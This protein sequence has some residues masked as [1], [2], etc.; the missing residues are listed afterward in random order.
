MAKSVDERVVQMEFDN[1]QFESGIKTSLNSLDKLKKGLNFDAATKSLA[2][3][4]K[5]TK[6]FSVAGIEKGIDTISSKFTTLGI[7]GVTALQRI[8]NA[9]I[10]AGTNLVKS[11]TIDPVLTG[12]NEYE[13][14]MN[15]ITTILTNTASKG[16]TLD[17]V[18]NA[19]NELNTYA[20][21]TIYNFAEMTRN[22][23][24]FTAAGVD[25]ETATKA[26]QGIANLAAGSGSSSAQAS[27]AMYQL[28]QAIAAGRVSLQDWN[29]V[30]NAGMGGELF[31]NALK[32]TAK[33]MGIVVDESVSF[34]ES[35]SAAGGQESWLTSDVLVKTLEKFAD[36]ETLLKAAT[37][38][39]TFT[40]LIDTM[41]ESVQSG[42]AQSWEYIIGDR[43][44]AAEL[45]TSISDG[46]NSIIQPSTDARNAALQFWNANGGRAAVIEGITNVLKTLGNILK[47]IGDAF[48]DAFPAITGERLVDISEKFRDLTENFKIGEGTAK[49]IKNTFSGLFSVVQ[50]FGKAIGA[51]IKP[52]F[53]FTDTLGTLASGLLSVTGGIGDFVTKLNQSDSIEQSL[54]TISDG[55]GKAVDAI[56]DFISSI[57]KNTGNIDGVLGD[58]I[59]GAVTIIE[60]GAGAL[61]DAIKWIGEHV[62]LGDVFAGLAGGGIFVAAKKLSGLFDTIKDALENL[63]GGGED[64]KKFKENFSDILSSVHDSIASFSTGIKVSSLLTISVAVGILSASLNSLSKLKVTDIAKSVTAVGILMT[65]LNLSFRS[66]TKSLSKFDS[67]GIL[68][69]GLST[70]AIAGAI[71]IL[72]SAMTDLAK[73]DLGGIGKGL[74]GIGGMLTEL[75]LFFKATD[76]KSISLKGSVGLIAIAGAI[77]IMADAIGE[78]ASLSWSEVARGL[79][80]MGIGLAELVAGIKILNG[81]KVSIST[82]IAIIALAEACVILSDAVKSFSSMSWE[83]IGR[84][85][86]SMGIALAELVAAVSILGK[87]GGF[88]SLLGGTSIL[89]I[90]QALHDIYESLSDFGSMSWGEIGKGLTAMGAA[91]T[92]LGVV[93]GVL[94]KIAGFSGILGSTTIVIAVQALEPIANTLQKIG[95]LSWEE[96]AKGLVGMGLAL[97][98][99]ALIVGTLGSFAGI[100]SLLAGGAILIA[101]QSLEPISNALQSIST[102]SWEEIAK[103]LVGMG[104][105]LGEVALIVG[106]LGMV[107][108]LGGILAGGA[109]LIAIQGLGD[110]ASALQQ[111][112]S[113]TWEEI[114]K[115]LVGMGAALGEL[116]I[117]TGLLG[118]L[119]PLGGIIGSG[120]ILI[121]VQ[122][123]GDLADALAKFGS[124]SWDEIGKGLA[125]MGAALGEVALGGLLNTLSGFGA[126]AIAEV[127]PALGTLADSLS[128]WKNVSVPEGLGEQ[129]GTLASGVMKFTFG[130]FGAGALST[131]AA[132]LGDMA[133]AVKKWQGV[134]I[135]EG[136]KE[137]LTNIADGVK[138]FTWAFMGGFSIGEI[139]E[140]LKNLA[141]AVRRW[142]GIEIPTN[143]KEGLSG[144][145]DGV[146]SF[147][148]AFIGGWS[149]GEIAEPLKNL[150]TA[151]RRWNG[152]EIPEGIGDS[153]SRLAK[154]VKSF[155]G[156]NYNTE[157]LSSVSSGLRSLGV[158]AMALSGINFALIGT[159]LS[160]FATAIKNIPS[161]ISGVS[162]SIQ[163]SVSQ[164]AVAISSQAGNVSA[165]F[166]TLVMSGLSSLSSM[167]PL[168]A[169]SGRSLGMSLVTALASSL[170]NGS[171]L[172]VSSGRTLGLSLVAALSVSLITGVPSVVASANVLFQ[173]VLTEIQRAIQNSRS[174][175]QNEGKLLGDALLKGLTSQKAQIASSL[176]TTIS[177]V[178]SRLNQYQ[179]S[180]RAAGSGM[181]AGLANGI[182]AG[183]SNVINAAIKVASDALAAAKRELDS[184]S[185]SKKFEKLGRDSDQGLING[186]LAMASRVG[187]AGK[188]VGKSALSSVG[189][190]MQQIPSLLS[191]DM[192][193]TPTITPVLDLDSIKTG[194]NT[195]DRMMNRGILLRP[196]GRI[197]NLTVAGDGV[198]GNT[199]NT[200][201]SY[202]QNNYSPKALS[203][204]EIYRQTRNQFST[205]K[206][207]V[208]G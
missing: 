171:S 63:F 191:D 21:K 143:L 116:A 22:I 148:W 72:T 170:I 204:K 136:I 24:T 96:I 137:G 197:S 166:S 146:K 11:L 14:K 109:I 151:V 95:A 113:M 62:S 163:S 180:F 167:G 68:R 85:L 45:F 126:G 18:N 112:G 53:G 35:I 184:H 19:L 4:E 120:S 104:L 193:I 33:Q 57:F 8:T 91:L 178:V 39:K 133:T 150:A 92:E 54:N 38:V 169:S 124:M 81:S 64:V 119:A 51:V 198:P 44:Q 156:E 121:A 134:E 172:C 82:S 47:P 9:A 128:K 200:T 194:M 79:T 94:G 131:A 108:P 106:A 25:L 90:T 154:G 175:I 160:N 161:E 65:E 165:A 176:D 13:T 3:I 89:I 74:L 42:W 29:S 130:G 107:A 71:A 93:S 145:A 117:I 155:G 69:A 10:T 127:A 158:S 99:V 5:A 142:S 102:L 183:R 16:T 205:I 6:N 78:L 186:L 70:I 77:S 15:A 34:R 49:N 75:S 177:S 138:A 189:I 110:L 115:G 55:L 31:Q 135:P 159:N 139:V 111:F 201:F 114:A 60:K 162:T 132:S 152:I 188:A 76:L 27:T 66:L 149:I 56:N 7:I 141:T 84:G 208:E 12:F 195:M 17:D 174:K 206:K 168:Y 199:G 129:L 164:I 123:L 122:G 80:A 202:V 87:F 48:K 83:E 140:P 179:G 196:N 207:R 185:P 125:A 37:Q 61:A 97:G 32:E 67:K 73:L 28:S 26:I 46:F 187:N 41:K 118:T 1:K 192:D 30:V 36:D 43:E 147:T 173:T 23:G 157:V 105:A 203:R 98:E 20:D 2:N 100:S 88:K 40:Q 182:L 181:S 153:L 103:G 144:L 50:L 52:V 190:M 101:V 59:N 58:F 86:T